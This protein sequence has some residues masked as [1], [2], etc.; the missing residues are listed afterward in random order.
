VLLLAVPLTIKTKLL[1]LFFCLFPFKKFYDLI[2][3][4]SSD[5]LV[6][7][8]VHEFETPVG[9]RTHCRDTRANTKFM[10]LHVAEYITIPK[11]NEK[12][13]SKL[14][15]ETSYKDYLEKN[16]ELLTIALVVFKMIDVTG[17]LK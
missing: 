3:Q 4:N 12:L 2:C 11:L 5:N 13:Q 15:K 14:G 8:S 9:S 16:T 7:L 17:A 1:R 10:L 6:S